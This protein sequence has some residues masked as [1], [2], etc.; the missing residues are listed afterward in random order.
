[1]HVDVMMPELVLFHYLLDGVPTKVYAPPSPTTSTGDVMDHLYTITGYSGADLLEK[2]PSRQHTMY[3]VAGPLME[4]EVLEHMKPATVHKDGIV[5]AGDTL[6]VIGSWPHAAGALTE[7][8]PNRM[9]LFVVATPMRT[10]H[11]Y[12]G[13][14]QVTIG[15][16]LL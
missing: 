16:S 3:S 8:M 12:K 9:V 2:P 15:A 5:R 6:R 4:P 11:P 7:A 10:M 14:V 13:Y 1:M